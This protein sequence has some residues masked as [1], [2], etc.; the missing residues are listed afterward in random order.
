MY[1]YHGRFQLQAWKQWLTKNVKNTT[2]K[3]ILKMRLEKNVKKM[4]FKNVKKCEKMWKKLQNRKLQ[5]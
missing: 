5:V 2:K 1:I 3:K 4:H